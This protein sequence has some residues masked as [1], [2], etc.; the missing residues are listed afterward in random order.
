M[1]IE[2]YLL[3]IVWEWFVNWSLYIKEV[4]LRNIIVKFNVELIRK[5]KNKLIWEFNIWYSKDWKWLKKLIGWMYKNLILNI[6]GKIL[7]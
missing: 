2:Y 7:N 1:L 5:F 3:L 4:K 6:F